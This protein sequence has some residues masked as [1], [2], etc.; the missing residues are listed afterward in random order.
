MIQFIVIDKLNNSINQFIVYTIWLNFGEKLGL[1][2][3]KSITQLKSKLVYIIFFSHSFLK[4][5]NIYMLTYNYLW[6]LSSNYDYN[7]QE[8]VCCV[9][10]SFCPRF[11]L[12]INLLRIKSEKKKRWKRCS[13]P[14]LPV[15]WTNYNSVHQQFFK[16]FLE[17]N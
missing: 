2:S 10:L 14:P 15:L 3:G 9:F 1:V 17:L 7:Y 12:I 6:A 5:M 4:M 13:P 11:T 8:K 16:S